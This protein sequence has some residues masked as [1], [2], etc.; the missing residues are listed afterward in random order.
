MNNIISTTIKNMPQT[1]KERIFNII[2][3]NKEKYTIT[4]HSI[5]IDY[6]KLSEKTQK[7]IKEIVEDRDCEPEPREVSRG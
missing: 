5:L 2:L 6:L 4:K 3:E 7:K 1:K